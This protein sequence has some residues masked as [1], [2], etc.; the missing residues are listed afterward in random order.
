MKIIFYNLGYGRG[1]VG[2][3]H[4]YLLRAHRFFYQGSACQKRQLQP[5]LDLVEK[6]KPDIFTYAEVC[7]GAPRNSYF[8]QH[9]YLAENLSDSV[10]HSATSK[11][12][13]SLLNRAP[14]HA[15]NSNG[16]I[17]FQEADIF[18]HYLSGSR[19]KLVFEMQVGDLTVFSVHLPLVD[20]HRQAH[21]QELAELI[22]RRDG[23]VVVCGDFNIL[24]GLDELS[25][26]TNETQL[27]IAGEGV[28]T[29]PA[30]RPL[31]QLDVFLYRFKDQALQPSLHTIDITASDHLPVVLEW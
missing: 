16:V 12:G 22:N 27:R 2:A 1:H 26:L 3:L 7:T 20:K 4:D 23:D 15:G 30:H 24:D 13:R 21:M 9:A 17:S 31:Y 8:D 19:K 5:V 14:F 18:G 28:N 11:Y 25:H 10:A 6:E 29:F